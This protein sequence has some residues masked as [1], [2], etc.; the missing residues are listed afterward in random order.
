M[1]MR[2]DVSY[3]IPATLVLATIVMMTSVG[4]HRGARALTGNDMLWEIAA[5]I[6]VAASFQGVIRYRWTEQTD[7]QA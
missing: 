5:A 2:T 7:G 4:N 6:F 3:P 1:S